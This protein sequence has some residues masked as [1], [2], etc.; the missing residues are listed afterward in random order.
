[1]SDPAPQQTPGVAARIL[2]W[3][4]AGYPEG[5]EPRDYPAVLG[6]LRRTLTEQ[7]LDSIAEDLAEQSVR[8]GEA[9]DA[10][11]I[12]AMVQ[13]H[14]FQK[15]SPED[16]FRVSARLAAGGWPLASSLD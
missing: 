15:A 10:A 3:L 12:H 14:A 2:G 5:I 16:M 8:T 13:E 11:D 7:D 4:K 6:V 9:I 1:M